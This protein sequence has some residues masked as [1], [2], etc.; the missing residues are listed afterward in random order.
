MG[1]RAA[2]PPN[3]GWDVAGA[4]EREVSLGGFRIPTAARLVIVLGPMVPSTVLMATAGSA[5][6]GRAPHRCRAEA[7]HARRNARSIGQ[8]FMGDVDMHKW[9]DWP[10]PIAGGTAPCAATQVSG[11][12]PTE[13]A[14]EPGPSGA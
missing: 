11:Y 6:A 7:G 9:N 13:I 1:S 5:P 14:L 8:C 4:S 3:G 10:I 2:G 12:L